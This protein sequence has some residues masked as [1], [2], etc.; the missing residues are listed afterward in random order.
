[1]DIEGDLLLIFRPAHDT[2]GQCDVMRMKVNRAMAHRGACCAA[3]GCVCLVMEE[4]EEEEDRP[5]GRTGLGTAAS[6]AE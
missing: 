4:D 2:T 5:W 6:C 3:A 1:M